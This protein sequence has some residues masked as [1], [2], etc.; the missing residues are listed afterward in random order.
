MIDSF[1][2]SYRF[3]SNFY[4]VDVEM[5]GET[6][7]SVEHAFQ[8]AKME[9]PERRGG[10]R[11]AMTPGD[12]KRMGRNLPLRPDWEEIKLLVMEELLRRKFAQFDKFDSRGT[13]ELLLTRLVNTRPHRLI[14]GN[15]W[16][17]TFWGECNGYGLNY[18]GYL[19][20]KIREE[21]P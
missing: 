7:P 20:E 14:E 10:I 9:D 5:F 8:A 3:L 4:W 1:S 2:G 17:D 21:V 6:Y 19:L 12:A 13:G 16:G 11:I 15:T 18:L